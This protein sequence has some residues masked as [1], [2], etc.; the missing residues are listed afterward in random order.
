MLTFLD[1]LPLDLGIRPC[2]N[3][4]LEPVAA[5]CL[6][7]S[8]RRP[9]ECLSARGDKTSIYWSSIYSL[10]KN[11]CLAPPTI[12]CCCSLETTTEFRGEKANVDAKFKNMAGRHS[13]S[14]IYSKL[15]AGTKNKFKCDGPANKCKYAK[16]AAIFSLQIY[17]RPRLP[18]AVHFCYININYTFLLYLFRRQDQKP[19]I[20]TSIE[21]HIKY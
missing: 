19:F 18:V 21:P 4:A 3:S 11:G 12:G 16:W 10:S 8:L 13:R 20:L 2:A 6:L 1:F 14:T 17:L 5:D 15:Q 9:Y 7:P